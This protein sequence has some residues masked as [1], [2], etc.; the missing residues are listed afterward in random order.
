MRYKRA[1]QQQL[2]R[3]KGRLRNVW[4]GHPAPALTL[5]RLLELWFLPC[6]YSKSL[7]DVKKL[8]LATQCTHTPQDDLTQACRSLI[9]YIEHQRDGMQHHCNEYTLMNLTWTCVHQ[10]SVQVI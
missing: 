6:T 10:A 5:V 3:H 7:G 9:K 8:L 4:P 1:L 2:Q